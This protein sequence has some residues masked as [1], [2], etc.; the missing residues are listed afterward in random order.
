MDTRG[1]ILAAMFTDMHKN[2]FQGL[3]ADKVIKE[4]AVTKG[5]MYHYFP[6][7]DAIG[8]AVIEE[9]IEPNYLKFYIDLD[10]FDGNP[11]DMLQFHLKELVELGTDDNISLGCPL[12]NLVQEM[13]PLNEDFRL[14]LK[15]IVDKMTTSVANSLKKGQK[16]D[17][18]VRDKEVQ[19]VADFFISSIEGAYSMAKV[20]RNLTLFKSNMEQLSFFLDILRG[21]NSVSHF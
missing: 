3:R 11:I 20:Q 15:H 19:A 6:S 13:S 8:L 1:K 4:M 18:V 12:N 2:G 7:K 9:I 14:K 10:S 16:K 17:F 5:A 21:P